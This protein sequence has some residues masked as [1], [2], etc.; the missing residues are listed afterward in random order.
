M[1]PSFNVSAPWPMAPRSAP[2][3]HATAVVAVDMARG[4]R[5]SPWCRAR[6]HRSRRRGPLPISPVASASSLVLPA[7]ST[8]RRAPH[9]STSTAPP[10]P[11]PPRAESFPGSAIQIEQPTTTRVRV[12][13]LRYRSAPGVFAKEPLNFPRFNPRSKS[14]QKYLQLSPV[15]SVLAPELFRNRTR[16]PEL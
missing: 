6:R 11:A 3:I 1:A 14:V 7:C 16:S 4:P 10:P 8:H 5:Q 9:P 12:K 13:R 2:I 15:L